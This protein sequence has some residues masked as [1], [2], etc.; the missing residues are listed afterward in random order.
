MNITKEMSINDC[1]KM[2]PQTKT[3][4]TKYNMGCLGCMGANAE[5]I[6]KGAMMHGLE[7]NEILN[8]LNKIIEEQKN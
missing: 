8:E 5:S 2:Y 1:L 4:F 6:E 7:I 3:V